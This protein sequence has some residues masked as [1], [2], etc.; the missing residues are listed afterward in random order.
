MT[1][2]IGF[3]LDAVGDPDGLDILDVGS[4]DWDGPGRDG[5]PRY[6]LE[7][8]ARSYLGV[9]V[10]E[11]P[12]VDRIV[13]VLD[14]ARTFGAAAFDVVI[15]DEVLEHVEDWRGAVANL[16]AVLRPGGLLV[17]EVPGPG[18]RRHA[19]PDDFWRFTLS[20]LVDI[21]GDL[22]LVRVRDDPETAGTFI[23]ARSHRPARSPEPVP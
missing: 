9:D 23:A 10:A 19:Y 21:L 13:D 7:P 6:E 18:F 11:G 16:K 5:S 4:R 8:R 22:R 12:A 15:C 3:V 1:H 17:V 2:H 14:L 20:D